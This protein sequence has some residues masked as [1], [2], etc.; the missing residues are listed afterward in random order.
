MNINRNP[1]KRLKIL[2]HIQD[3]LGRISIAEGYSCDTAGRVFRSQLIFGEDVTQDAVAT[4]SIVEAPRPDMAFYAGEENAWRR[5][6]WTLIIQGIVPDDRNDTTD[7]IYYLCQDVERCLS[8]ISAVKDHGRPAFPEDYLLGGKITSV[9]IA[10]PVVRP[11]EARV[12]RF[13][14]FYLPL[15]VGVASKIG[16]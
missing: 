11:P 10:S 2:Q 9:E 7:D 14:F 3:M 4:L 5:D 6:S 12:S 13:S 1:P 16:E 15:R 8:R